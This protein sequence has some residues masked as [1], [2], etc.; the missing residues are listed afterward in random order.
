MV[1]ISYNGYNIGWNLLNE[2]LADDAYLDFDGKSIAD[3]MG[4]QQLDNKIRSKILSKISSHVTYKSILPNTDIDVELF[5]DYVKESIILTSQSGS[6][7]SFSY[8]MDADG[9]LATLNEDGSICFQDEDQIVFTIPAPFMFD[10]SEDAE[11]NYNICVEL[12][13]MNDGW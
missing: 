7:T 10:Q 12:E 6:P 13:Q 3:Y 4:I 2:G 1:S 8:F 11:M 5:S 9:L